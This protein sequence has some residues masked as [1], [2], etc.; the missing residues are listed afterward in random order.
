MSKLRRKEFFPVLEVA[1]L[2]TGIMA[3]ESENISDMK[4]YIVDFVRTLTS[5]MGYVERYDLVKEVSERGDGTRTKFYL[6]FGVEAVMSELQNNDPVV[7][8]EVFAYDETYVPVDA[9]FYVKFDRG[10][11]VNGF[12]YLKSRLS[13]SFEI[14]EKDGRPCVSIKASEYA[15]SFDSKE[16]NKFAISIVPTGKKSADIIVAEINACKQKGAAFKFLH[17]REGFFDRLSFVAGKD[18]KTFT[19]GKVFLPDN[20]KIMLEAL[21]NKIVDI[22]FA[23]VY[24]S[25]GKERVGIFGRFAK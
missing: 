15:R 16:R 14:V 8:E 11:D 22:D 2:N 21:A 25:A 9:G 1:T 7:Y 4:E 13:G 12:Y 23:E 19:I 5:N 24:E 17:K 6:S 20:D 3:T 10:V 18:G